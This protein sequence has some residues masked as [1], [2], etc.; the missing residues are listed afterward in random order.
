MVCAFAKCCNRAHWVP[1][2]EDS[3]FLG[4]KGL[5][6]LSS[7][8]LLVNNNLVDVL[9]KPRVRDGIKAIATVVFT[10]AVLNL[11]AGSVAFCVKVNTLKNHCVS[12]QRL[13]VVK[14]LST[15]KCALNREAKEAVNVKCTGVH[16][17]LFT[18]VGLSNVATKPD[19]QVV[20]KLSHS[21][22]LKLRNLK[23]EVTNAATLNN[24]AQARNGVGVVERL[25]CSWCR[26]D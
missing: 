16:D 12:H 6:L 7:E 21:K 22:A 10:P 24:V 23:V 3:C 5:E 26:D 20:L 17:A 9:V 11:P 2:L 19:R 18:K 25:I 8:V 13:A 4:L 1:W 15:V 14:A